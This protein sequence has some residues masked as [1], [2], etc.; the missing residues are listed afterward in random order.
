MIDVKVMQESFLCNWFYKLLVN[1]DHSKWTS[2]PLTLL[3]FIGQDLSCFSS[4]IGVSLFKGIEKIELPCWKK[5]NFLWLPHNKR[6]NIFDTKMSCIWNNSNVT[7]Q[8]KVIFFEKW[9]QKVT[10]LMNS[11]RTTMSKVLKK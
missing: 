5:V 10:F 2:I 9:A 6:H 7:Y 8:N 4:K 3:K 1:N 11:Q